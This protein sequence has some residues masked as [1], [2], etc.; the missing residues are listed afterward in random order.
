LRDD[1]CRAAVGALAN[2]VEAS[3]PGTNLVYITR[4]VP[5]GEGPQNDIWEDN[6]PALVLGEYAI[7]IAE[8]GRVRS[9]NILQMEVGILEGRRPSP[10]PICEEMLG[11]GSRRF[12]PAEGVERRRGRLF[13][14]LTLSRLD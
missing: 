3:G 4:F 2:M 7:E 6:V 9:C 13:I 14:S 1:E 11:E 12:E 10:P 8:D 5:E